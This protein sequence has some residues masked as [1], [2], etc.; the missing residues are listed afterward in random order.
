MILSILFMRFKEGYQKVSTEKT[1]ELS[2]NS[3]YEILRYVKVNGHR[4]NIAYLSI[5]FMRF[6]P[7]SWSNLILSLKLSILFMRFLMLTVALGVAGLELS[8]LFMRLNLLRL[9]RR[10]RLESLSILFMRF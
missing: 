8:I 3:L 5:L 6:L 1:L 10:R 2:F 4:V 9:M 7:F